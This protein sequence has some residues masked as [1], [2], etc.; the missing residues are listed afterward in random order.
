MEDAARR[1]KWHWKAESRNGGLTM[2]ASSQPT[3]AG[4]A[5]AYSTAS[6]SITPATSAGHD[7]ASSTCGG[8]TALTRG[9]S[10]RSWDHDTRSGAGFSSAFGGPGETGQ[11]GEAHQPPELEALRDPPRP[12][13]LRMQVVR[14]GNPRLRPLVLHAFSNRRSCR[15]SPV[16]ECPKKTSRT[17]ISQRFRFQ[18]SWQSFARRSGIDPALFTHNL[19]LQRM[20]G[21]NY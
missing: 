14:G 13:P 19:R 7:I 2:G 11:S 1:T 4:T 15:A 6:A 3:I 10:W 8:M 5:A 21:Q 12:F 16:V 17:L 20:F 18:A 9:P